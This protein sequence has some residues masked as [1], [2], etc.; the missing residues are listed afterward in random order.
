MKNNDRYDHEF[1]KHIQE[2]SQHL[3]FPEF[4]TD[5]ALQQVW[6][7]AEP[8]NKI[9]S[10]TLWL[11][12]ASVLVV[13]LILSIAVRS[14]LQRKDNSQF[15]EIE[16]KMGEKLTISLPDGNRVW[17]NS[18]S[19][20]KYPANFT[21]LNRRIELTGEAYFEI[22]NNTLSPIMISAQNTLINCDSALFNVKSQIG[23]SVITV[24]K[25]W[26]SL[27]NTALPEP[28]LVNAG[29]KATLTPEMPL[30][31][32]TFTSENNLAWKTGRL[33]FDQTPLITV[34][35]ELSD[36]YGVKVEIKGSMKYCD[37]TSTY[38]KSDIETIISDIRKQYPSVVTRQRHGYT[39]EGLAGCN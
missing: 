35:K 3:S 12:I 5:T 6:N 30:F 1:A 31:A 16:V 11:K 37:L 38:E 27:S 26:V 21:G 28:Y 13:G 33:E 36:C 32:E 20:I 22:K 17:L 10:Y 8:K 7:K 14:V 18:G 25:G 4:D 9:H 2:A 29:E 15:V 34:A 39:I 24:E 19:S 23:K